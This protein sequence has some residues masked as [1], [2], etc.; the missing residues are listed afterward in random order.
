MHRFPEVEEFRWRYLPRPVRVW[1]S[2]AGFLLQWSAKGGF[3]YSQRFYYWRLGPRAG[4]KQQVMDRVWEGPMKRKTASAMASLRHHA[5]PDKWLSAFPQLNEFMTAAVYEGE[6]GRRDSPTVT[7]WASGG[8][9][10][11]TVKD[12]AEG[13]VMW[14]SAGSLRELVKLMDTFVLA[15]DGPWRHDDQSHSRNGK[16]V[17]KDA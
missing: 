15:E 8:E 12:R 2:P 1:I 5:E 13:L 6:E 9:W 14:L 16:R 11:A 3:V 10:K 7:I 17:R 4:R